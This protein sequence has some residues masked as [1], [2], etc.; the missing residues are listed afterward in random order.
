M[1]TTTTQ[2][3][4]TLSRAKTRSAQLAFPL[5]C[6]GLALCLLLAAAPAR[7]Q[8]IQG[9]DETPSK[10]ESEPVRLRTQL[11]EATRDYKANL[12]KLVTIY[13]ADAKQAEGRL[14]KMKELGAQKLITRRELE[15][16]EDAAARARDKY[17]DAQ[18]QLRASDVQLAEAL[19]EVEVEETAPKLKLSPAPRAV[20]GLVRTTAY[21]RY[22]GGRA[23]SLSEASAIKQ[24]FV[25]RFGRPLPIHVFGQ[26]PL[27]DRWGY[28]HR[29]AMDIGL[30]PDSRE[31]QA[32]VEYLR[33]N[34]IPFTAF[35]FAIPGVATGPHIH[36]WLPSHRITST[37]ASRWER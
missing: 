10:S 19:I 34:G 20:G 1:E 12:E 15:T 4:I 23:W 5:V 9:R 16:S 35:H 14:Q 28:D 37:V 21:I 26:S 33:A 2:T 11:A 18:A 24:F 3:R 29:N 31:G 6:A 7:G 30:N 36:V 13:E 17:V 25:A 32:L 27:H 22:G 8:K